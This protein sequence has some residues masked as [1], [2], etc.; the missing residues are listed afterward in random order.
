MT[1]IKFEKLDKEISF[2]KDS[3]PQSFVIPEPSKKQ[4]EWTDRI[5]EWL[6]FDGPI[7]EEAKTFIDFMRNINNER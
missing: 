2:F 3:M 6:F 1:R 4:K 7:P 5:C